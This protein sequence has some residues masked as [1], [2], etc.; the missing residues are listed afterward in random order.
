MQDFYP[1]LA[2][3]LM[4]AFG[5]MAGGILADYFRV[6]EG[7]MSYILHGA[8][9]IILAVVAVELLPQAL[10]SGSAAEV[11]LAFALGGL[12]YVGLEWLLVW[13][14]ERGGSKKDSPRAWVIYIGLAFD[15]F[16][17]GI[18]I[19]VGILVSQGLALLLAIGAAMSD[20][21]SAFIAIAGFKR[22]GISRTR[23]LLLSVSFAVIVLVGALTGY[24]IGLIG[25]ERLTVSLLSYTA[26]VILLVVVEG[27]MVETHSRSPRTFLS[28]TFLITGA[29]A[30]TLL[31]AYL[32]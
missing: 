28:E 30:F 26:G 13:I 19:A 25:S 9:G 31:S 27:I 7:T 1:A 10:G 18:M 29:A 21:P 15:F 24:G 6:S 4:P 22:Q 16:T 2:L 20:L 32:E 5:S 23:S 8:A 3:S 14:A 11:A 12:T 17:D